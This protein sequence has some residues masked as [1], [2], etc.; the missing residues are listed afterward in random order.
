MGMKMKEEYAAS[1]ITR[2]RAGHW[3][4]ISI[5]DDLLVIEDLE[6]KYS[7]GYLGTKLR[8]GQMQV[9][10]DGFVVFARVKPI[11]DENTKWK[12]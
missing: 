4:T 9:D 7:S 10:A 8:F 3:R 1:F 6:E 11:I 12:L 5:H 2:G